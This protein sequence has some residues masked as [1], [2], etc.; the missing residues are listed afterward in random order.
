M[1]FYV[2]VPTLKSNFRVK[3]IIWVTIIELQMV[4]LWTILV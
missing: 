4:Y 3:L 1:K 2:E